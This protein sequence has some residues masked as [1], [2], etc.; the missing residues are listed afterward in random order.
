MPYVTVDADVDVWDFWDD[1]SR[2]EKEE[3]R[4]LVVEEFH[5]PT[6][7]SA[8]SALDSLMVI[9]G[10]GEDT[11]EARD[12]VHKVAEEVAYRLKVRDFSEL[13]VK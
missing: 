12:F 6:H 13:V 9:L 5:L 4:D 8:P 7:D 11:I 1:C 10:D 2:S 3:L